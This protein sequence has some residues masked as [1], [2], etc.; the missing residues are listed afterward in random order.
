MGERACDCRTSAWLEYAHR[1]QVIVQGKNRASD[2]L[3]QPRVILE[4]QS[5]DLSARSF[6]NQREENAKSPFTD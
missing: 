6:R 3:E 5:E 2:N 4:P 1:T